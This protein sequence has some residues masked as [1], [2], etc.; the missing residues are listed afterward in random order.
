MLAIL[1]VERACAS[2]QAPVG[3]VLPPVILMD[4]E[5]VTI[6]I[7]VR[8][9]PGGQ[10]CPS[11]PA[12]ALRVDLPEPLGDRRLLDGSTLPAREPLPEL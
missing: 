3:R 5:S 6:V 2:G 12:F 11:N 7:G 4:A 8:S 9:A 10:R 1:L